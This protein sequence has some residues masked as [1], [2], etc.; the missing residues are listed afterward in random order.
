MPATPLIQVAKRLLANVDAERGD[1][2][3]SVQH[4]PVRNYRDTRRFDAEIDAIFWRSPLMVALSCDVA[5]PGEFSAL[6]IAGRPILVVRGD[7][8]VARTFLNICRHRG[9]PITKECFGQTRRFTCPYHFWVYDTS[10]SLVGNTAKE[11]FAGLDVDGLIE[12]PTAERA[13]LV[14]AVLTPNAP[15]DIDEWLGDMASALQILELDKLVRHRDGLRAESGNWKVTADGYVDGYHLGFLHRNSIGAKSITNRNTYDLFGPHVRLGFANKPLLEMRD[16]PDDEW[17]LRESMSLVHYIFPNVS[18]SGLPGSGLMVSRIMPGTRPARCEVEQ[19]Q[20]FR[21]LMVT[22]AQVTEADAKREL[23]IAVT[24]DEDFSTVMNITDAL[25]AIPDDVFRYG[26]N[27]IGNQNLHRWV[28]TLVE[29]AAT[30]NDST[31]TTG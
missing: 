2:V 10:G 18:I 24:R 31:T 22:D 9:A 16:L 8:G 25:G 7:D 13:G 20:Y 19:L 1:F 6:S 14:F 3:E 17:R 28:D 4:V 15:I 5:S 21:E 26:R 29:A 11:A 23:Y 30:G 12:L 27:E